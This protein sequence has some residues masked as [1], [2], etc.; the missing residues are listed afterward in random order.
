[1]VD[2]FLK[3]RENPIWKLLLKIQKYILIFCGVICCLIFVI[4]VI[5][6]YVLK[7]DFLGYDEIVLLFATWLYFIGGSY[8]MY[9]KS[10]ISADVLGLVIKGR[11]LETGRVAV[12]WMT[13][14][15]TVVLAVWGIDF[16]M[17]ALESPA[18][19]TVWR[20]PRIWAQSALM[21][22]YIMMAFYSLVYAAEDT[23]LLIRNKGK[24]DKGNEVV[25]S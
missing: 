15:I 9:Q 23:I 24:K 2:K 10:H 21:V 12:A 4:E 6:R 19:T 16:L 7:I 14:I 13:L 8:A 25:E 1:M 3:F 20:M 5:V 18:K 11:K 22:G 17:Y